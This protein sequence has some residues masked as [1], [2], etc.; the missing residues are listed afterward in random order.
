[1]P[2][3]MRTLKMGLCLVFVFLWIQGQ[4]AAADVSLAWDASTSANIAGYKAYT[5]KRSGIYGTPIII[6]NQTTYTATGLG[7][8]TYYFAVTAFDTAG[9]ESGFSN[10]VSVTLSS[11]S[12][13][14]VPAITVISPTSNT[15]Y[16]TTS[17][18][19]NLAGT[20]ADNVG[21]TQVIWANSLGGGGT[22]AGTTNWSVSGI[23]LQIGSNVLTVTARDAAG[24]S[25]SVTLTVYYAP[26]PVDTASSILANPGFESGVNPWA[27]YTDAIGTFENNPA[28]NGSPHSGHIVIFQPGSNVQLNQAGLTLE[29]NTPYRLSFSAYSNTGHDVSVSLFQHGSP[30]ADYGLTGYACDLATIWSDCSVEFW[31]SGFTG[32]V[33]DGRLMFWFPP[34][35]SAG[36]QYYIDDVVLEKIVATDTTRPAI[37]ITNPTANSS[38][39]TTS[40]SLSIGETS[41]DNVGVTQVTWTNSLGAAARRAAQPTGRF[42]ALCC[43]VDRMSSASRHATQ[44]GTSRATP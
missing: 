21:V 17:S 12:D 18:L 25:V 29:A 26:N 40:A 31:T 20:A 16:S 2:K 37:T 14:T 11:S 7:S 42:P 5:G 10:E 41:S 15:T 3:Y 32:T 27:F 9:N 19:I 23:A 13:T 24:N 30:Y 34:Y 4:G 44:R 33:N 36:D 35:S 38:Y 28:G 43:E 6:P 8:G 1:M 39:S 22:A